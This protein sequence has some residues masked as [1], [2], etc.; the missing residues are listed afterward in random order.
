[1]LTG[2][3]PFYSKNWKSMIQN[4][5]YSNIKV[6]TYVSKDAQNLLLLLLSKEP[7]KWLGAG[8]LDA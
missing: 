3:P 8:E 5:M 2:I 6:P 7:K 4:I 1:M